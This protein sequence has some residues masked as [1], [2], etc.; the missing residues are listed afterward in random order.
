VDQTLKQVPKDTR[1][2]SVRV[3]PPRP[4]EALVTQPR[5]QFKKMIGSKSRNRSSAFAI[6]ALMCALATTSEGTAQSRDERPWIELTTKH[7]VL[8]T[9]ADE[10][11]GRRVLDDFES[12]YAAYE[13]TIFPLEPRQFPIRVFLFDVLQ[14]FETFLPDS[15]KTQ[16]NLRNN[17]VPERSAYLFRGAT[18]SF[19]ALR[20]RGVD[21]LS[22]DVGHSLGHLF[23]ARS[24]LWQPFWLQEG[25][26]EF[27]RMLGQGGG[28]DPV[29]AEDA[30][31]LD[32]ILEIVPS[33]S[34]NDIGD[35]GAF[36]LQSYHLFRVLMEDHA[37]TLA[38][39]VESLRFAD[40]YNPELQLDEAL[41]EDLQSRVLQYEDRG[42]P[43]TELEVEVTVRNV[44]VADADR[45]KG[46]L[47]AAAGL[48][49]FARAH[50][51]QSRTDEAR[52]GLALLSR[53]EQQ[54]ESIR[55][56]LE[57]LTREL[58]DS[59]LAH[60]HFGSLDAATPEER[61]LQITAMERSIELL[62]LMGRAYAHLGAL[63]V[64]EGRPDDA[65]QLAKRAIALEPEFADR[66]FEVIMEARLMLGDNDAATEAAET[67]ATL[68]HWDPGTLEHYAMLVPEL[69]RTL[70]QIRRAEDSNRL[71][72][73]RRE[74]E[75][76]A[77]ERDPRPLPTT[78]G[79]VPFG[80]V[81]YDTSSN[82][83]PG[84]SEPRLVSGDLPEYNPDLRRR[85]IQGQVVLDVDLDRQGRVSGTGVR[86]SDDEELAV[87]AVLALRR[88]R[89]DP[90][91]QNEESI[92]FSFRLTFTFDLQE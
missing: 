61:R 1:G 24:V 70:E 71:E 56:G 58:P 91:R 15:V 31:R 38:S 60:Y 18:H 53:R 92:A 9:D 30:Y 48:N 25:V 63:Y 67:A 22:D 17:P 33:E 39:Y 74:V 20:D 66:A 14:D 46:D 59:G 42:I 27:V 35:G 87:A 49:N 79:A 23:L 8:L 72:E 10:E 11:K 13:S 32:E 54:T 12:R 78:G 89:F 47:A 28:E 69:Y 68:P 84:V 4:A 83:P 40:G 80:L 36:R 62:P 90:A 7:F 64:E 16:L 76:L 73:L 77:D 55:L 19:I 57:Q 21:T 82:P 26:G 75:A 3:D 51:Q 52:L 50:Y 65:I 88:W 37:Q 2:S 34:F 81:H 41:F 6:A 29:E 85:G 5:R 43:L 44:S 45:A 86:S